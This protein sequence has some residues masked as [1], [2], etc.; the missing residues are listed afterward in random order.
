MAV[1]NMSEIK[2]NLSSKSLERH[3]IFHLQE[4]VSELFH[5]AGGM[6]RW[7]VVL[8]G[9]TTDLVGRQ[10]EYLAGIWGYFAFGLII[11]I[12]IIIKGDKPVQ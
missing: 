11:I 1:V 5:Q 7:K 2:P 12:I 4:E 8:W 3:P 9:T 6:L 10:A